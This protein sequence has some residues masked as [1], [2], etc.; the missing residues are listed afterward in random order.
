M[1]R[2]DP[3][4][5]YKI[6]RDFSVTPEPAQGGDPND[7]APV[8]VIQKH[9]ARNL[10]YD[11]RLELD[12][13]M[14]SWAVPKGPSLDPTD[15]RMAVHV[16][17]HPLSYNQFE[18]R[19]P[20]GQYG[21]GKVIIWDRGTW[22]PEQDPRKAYRA[23]KLKFVL[24]GSKLQ[25]GWALV[26]MR[27]DAHKQDTW[28]LIKENDEYARPVAEF[29]VV[30]ELPDSVGPEQSRRAQQS[31]TRPGTVKTASKVAL[32]AKPVEKAP[33][34][35]LPAALKP[36]LATLADAAPSDPQNW[37][38]EVKFDG[39]RLLARIDSKSIQLL[40]RNGHDWTNRL[41]HLAKALRSLKLPSGWYD[42]EIVSLN[43]RGLPD[44]QALQNA[45][46]S[47]KTSDIQYFVFDLPY[48]KG[49]DLRGLPLIRRR[50]ILEQTLQ[51]AITG[52]ESPVQLSARFDAPLRDIQE[53][54]CRMGLEGVIVKL[55]D[56]PYVSRRSTAWLKLKCG[57]R[58]EFVIGGYTQPQGSR[59]GIG[60]LLLGVHDEHGRLRYAGKVGTGFSSRSLQDLH[61][62]LERLQSDNSP[63]GE[64]TPHERLA[65]WIQPK[66]LAEVSFA[67]WTGSGRIRHA[68]FHGLRNDKP[69]KAITREQSMAATK[70]TSTGQLKVTHPD[71]IVDAATDTRK[72][73]VVR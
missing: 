23:G 35:A 65:H 24:K 29:S 68:V 5:Q 42:G 1:A 71:R 34:A 20:Q 7:D 52:G 22:T 14:K 62:R 60:A 43:D 9:W 73:D 48:F 57:Q 11:F 69:P 16:E 33:R 46:D 45:F 63:F 53:S 51:G 40:T 17:D 26:R 27:G 25:G 54:A 30:D 39:Y 56:S 58:Q 50:E 72:I 44:F 32:T 2:S 31:L 3:L 36:Q 59:V 8:F 41:P 61:Q 37:L 28:L 15:K 10:H 21:A 12:G 6:K 70:S 38:Y 18:G 67:Q 64:D 66:L 19:I 49:K 4:K 55:K 47:A 13:V